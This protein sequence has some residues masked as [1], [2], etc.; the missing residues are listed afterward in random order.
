V[1]EMRNNPV[2]GRE[3]IAFIDDDR[4]KQRRH[5]HGVPVLAADSADAL[6]TIL[7]NERIDEVVISTRRICAEKL[8]LLRE[9]CQNR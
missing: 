4:G 5:L 8:L 7:R 3:P 2:L 6:A 9:V 1:R